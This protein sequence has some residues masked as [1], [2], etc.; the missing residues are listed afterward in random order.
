[1]KYTEVL[2][3]IEDRLGDNYNDNDDEVLESIVKEVINLASY[4]S[5]REINT[6]SENDVKDENLLILSHEIINAS[7]VAY[8]KRGVESVK[9]QSE[10]GQSN[11][12]VDYTEKLR[13]DIIKNGKRIIL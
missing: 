12:F 3:I 2:Q 10:L 1:M 8:Q 5:N 4:I 6:N 13:N 11:T 9:S 7:I